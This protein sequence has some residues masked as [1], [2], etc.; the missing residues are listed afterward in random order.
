MPYGAN[1][2]GPDGIAALLGQIFM[3]F[4]LQPDP[5]ELADGG[6]FVVARAA[7]TF[8]A[9]AT[10]RSLHMPVVELYDVANGQIQRNRIFYQDTKALV[11]LLEKE[12]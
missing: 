1:H 11:E 5:I 2:V 6:S 9:R 3:T 7:A 12:E 8:T 4:E 10:G